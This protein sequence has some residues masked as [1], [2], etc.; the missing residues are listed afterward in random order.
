MSPDQIA[1]T[2]QQARSR[3]CRRPEATPANSLRKPVGWCTPTWLSIAGRTTTEWNGGEFSALTGTCTKTVIG[4]TRL[5]RDSNAW[6]PQTPSLGG[7][8][9]PRQPTRGISDAWCVSASWMALAFPTASRHTLTSQGRDHCGVNGQLLA[10]PERKAVRDDLDSS[11]VRHW[12][13]CV[14]FGEQLVLLHPSACFPTDVSHTNFRGGPSRFSTGRPVSKR[15][16]GWPNTS[17]RA[18]HLQNRSSTWRGKYS[19]T[20]SNVRNSSAVKVV[21]GL[22][23]KA[24]E[25]PRTHGPRCEARRAW[26][27]VDKGGKCRACCKEGCREQQMREIANHESTLPPQD[28]RAAGHG[29]QGSKIWTTWAPPCLRLRA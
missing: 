3:N 29:S 6:P 11:L 15:I 18:P 8:T 19:L 2:K 12:H 25:M 20:R 27:S 22:G 16:C 5:L 26:W 10:A 28:R 17:N 13:H 14:Q 9:C 1:Q 7:G 4:G 21:S 23:G 24:G